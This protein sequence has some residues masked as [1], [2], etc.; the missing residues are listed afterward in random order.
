LHL[1]AC[2]WITHPRARVISQASRP[3]SML[4]HV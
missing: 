4:P 3:G 2:G 1:P